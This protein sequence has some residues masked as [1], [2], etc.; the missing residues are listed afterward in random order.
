MQTLA[1]KTLDDADPNVRAM[2]EKA[3]AQVGFIPNRWSPVEVGW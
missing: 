2:P 1:S 3:K